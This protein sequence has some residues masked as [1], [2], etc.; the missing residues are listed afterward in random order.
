MPLQLDASGKVKY[1]VLAR[2]GQRKDKVQRYTYTYVFIH[3]GST[4]GFGIEA[5]IH[6]RAE[7]ILGEAFKH[8]QL[9]RKHCSANPRRCV[10]L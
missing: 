4:G 2:M 3:S 7:Y 8:Y 6:E 1:D 10:K 9:T 5:R